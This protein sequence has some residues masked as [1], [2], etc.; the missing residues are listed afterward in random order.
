MIETMAE[1]R[2]R[3][4]ERLAAAGFQ[5]AHSLP[6]R[7]EDEITLRP[8]SDIAGRFAA[9]LGLCLYVSAPENVFPAAK[10]GAITDRLKSR[11]HLTG[12]EGAVLDLPRA[13][14]NA[15]HAQNIGW[16][17]ENMVSLAWVLGHP[18]EPAIDGAMISGKPLKTI[19]T[20]VMP[21]DVEGA[22]AWAAAAHARPAREVAAM[23]DLFYCCHNAVRSAQ[24]GAKGAVPVGFHPV[25]N[26]GVIHER[27]HALTWCLS[28][29]VSWSETDLST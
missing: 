15:A 7:S 20:G 9:L 25:M 29:D 27:R 12:E 18:L 14:A 22:A 24:I 1:V 21:L 3:S 11:A 2:K 19:V 5:Y 23:E 17:M 26:G 16:R 8:S 13:E 28:P 4:A 6:I 10:L